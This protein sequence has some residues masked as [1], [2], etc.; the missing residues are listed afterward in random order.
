M[1][2][3]IEVFT[4][5]NDTRST[6]MEKR[7]RSLNYEVQTATV[8]DVYTVN[9]DFSANDL[10]KIGGMLANPI[11]QNFT[12]DSPADLE[13]SFALEIGFLPGVTDN[14]AHSAKESIEDFF[15]TKFS[16][17]ESVH[18]STLLFLQG[19]LTASDT[20]KI[21][22]DLANNLIQRINIKNF[23]QYQTDKGMDT[24]VPTVHLKSHPQANE[25][26]LDLSEEDLLKLGKEGVLDTDGTRRGPLALEKDSL[27][28]I[29]NYFTKE[30]RNPTDIELES[31]AQTWSEHCKH[32]IFAAEID[33]NKDGL[34]KGFIKKAT[35]EIRKQKGTNDF[36][37]SVFSD[38]A[39]GIVLDENWVITDKAETHN[40]PSALDPFG[41]AITGIV[42]VN[43]D[44]IGFGKGAKP[45]INKY[46]FCLG[47]PDDTEPI[48]RDK[49]LSNPAL[50]PKR[51][52]EG[53]VAGVNAGGNCSGIPTPQGFLYFDDS[54]KGKP[55]IF[56]GTVGLIPRE[57]NHKPS[58][59]KSAQK[60]DKIV[61]V[62]GRVGQDGIHGA[63]F[64]SEALS[65]GSPAT[66][67]QIGDPIT[68]KKFSDA[69]I[70]EARDL[71]LY[72]SITDN[73]AGGISCSVAE[74]AKECGGCLVELEK[75][76]LKYPNLEPWKIW[77]SESQE[78]MTLAV[79]PEK[80]KQ[81]TDLMEK[82]GV[83][84][85]VI[86]EFTDSGRCQVSYHGKV[87]MDLSMEFLHDGL[88]R[89]T[90]K[91]TYT[92][93]SHPEANF[94][95]PKN[96]T[97]TLHEILERPNICSYEFISSQYDHVVQG[98][99]VLG[100]LQGKGRVNCITSVTRALPENE[101]G[102]ICSQ[103]IFPLYSEIDTYDMAACSIDAAVR[104][105][106][107]AGGTL[108]HLALMDNFC[109]CSSD[110]S[111]RLGQLKAACQAC[112]D[113][114]VAYG[115]PY[116]SGKDSMF[117]DFKGFD[118]NGTSIKIS[119]LPTLLIS[120]L[121]VMQDSTKAVSLDPKIPGDL[122]YILGETHEEL[123]G[124]EYFKSQNFIGNR[125]PKVDS[126]KAIALY[127]KF[128][129]ATDKRL[130]ASALSPSHGGLLTALAKKS[131][132][133]KLGMQIDLSK[134]PGAENFQ[135][136]D[137]LCFSESAS[138]IIVTIDPKRQEEFEAHFSGLPYAQIGTITESQ[139]FII[140]STNDQEIIKT[141]VENLDSHYRQTFKNY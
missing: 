104:N 4:K 101:K 118:K 128:T 102:I 40:S 15:K 84:V 6:V 63:T 85:S 16:A 124:S 87:I 78:R 139:E 115:T 125:T 44:T 66:A 24:V 121:G 116:I 35:Q 77:I 13:F 76:P 103:G 2:H 92:K 25:V 98:I 18:T 55:L 100:P 70:K 97:D 57:I 38:N 50:P 43:R 123:G 19:K 49:D 54:Y 130:I 94:P 74:M 9:K 93:V 69:I 1:A 80:L 109:W 52:F 51:I 28:V 83:E 17:E 14:I 56:V 27:E 91:T 114:A 136:S 81:F 36:C 61:V 59:E 127:K 64:S 42:G 20:E 37:V 82:R 132:A 79:S 89:K 96:L 133:A 23:S 71:D 68:Q 5:V 73:G 117:N 12:I 108:D 3:R 135:R 11:S 33:D 86:G 119:A 90:L 120:S 72:T 99:A 65:S 105:I 29:K 111:H 21:G 112:Y 75:V 58:W 10:E 122:I 39:G 8:V 95:E 107:A 30:G 60:G 141:T 41:G 67:V 140:K 137:Y 47:N 106:I 131:I 134:I 7:L 88:P 113:Y 126:Q 62:G 34:Y 48:Y 110:E 138:R 46:G 53:V 45:I 31:L 22:N 26:S 32:T 129:E